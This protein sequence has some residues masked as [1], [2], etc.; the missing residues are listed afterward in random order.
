MGFHLV[1]GSLTGGRP[2]SRA[3]GKKC[4]QIAIFQAGDTNG[5][6]PF[7]AFL[8]LFSGLVSKMQRTAVSGLPGAIFLRWGQKRIKIIALEFPEGIFRAGGKNCSK[9]PFSSFLAQFSGLG[10]KIDPNCRFL[11]PWGLIIRAGAKNCPKLL[12]SNFL[13]PFSGLVSKIALNCRFQASSNH[14]PGL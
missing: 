6:K 1:W 7:P 12:F 14:F 13:G 8:V 11:A 10:P 3:R 9:L 5:S 4:H 2:G